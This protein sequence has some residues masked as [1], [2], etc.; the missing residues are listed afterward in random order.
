MPHHLPTRLPRRAILS[1]AAATLAAI[2]M[3]L[4]ASWRV[5][6]A[7]GTP[8]PVRLDG[9]RGTLRT[10]TPLAELDQDQVTQRLAAAGLDT[11]RVRYGIAAFRLVYDTIDATGQPTTAGA[12]AVLPRRGER[13][14]RVV[15]WLHGTTVYRGDVASL[16]E[17]SPDRLIAFAFAA[18]GYAVSAPD[19]LGL[20]LGPGYHPFRDPSSEV[21]AALD[22]L[23]AT[24]ALAEREGHVLD[25]RILVSG[26]SQGGPAAMA[27]GRALQEGADTQ[28][29]L[30]ALAPVGGPFDTS[31]TLQLALENEIDLAAAY[32]A[33]LVVAWNRLHHLYDSPSEAFQAPYDA[34]VETLIDG[35]HRGEEILPALP[36]TPA[37]LFTPAFMDRLR[38][39]SGALQEALAEADGTCDWRPRIQ[40]SIYASRGDRDVPIAN[41]EYCQEILQAH[42]ADARLI[43]VGNVDHFGSLVL[44]LPRIIAQFDAAG[45]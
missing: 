21:T 40:V 41:A 43:D 30:G 33:Y 45:S 22:A 26:F 3:P 12:L 38:E 4:S 6:A 32:L 10:V 34:T 29:S 18:A 36:A 27:L 23:Q 37:E 24:R 8:E 44:S 20:G 11:A 31:G 16:A 1:A 39:P 2:A 17:E 7:S 15:C 25:G 14:L 19:Y 42:G 13:D 28:F 9:L 5:A 35:E